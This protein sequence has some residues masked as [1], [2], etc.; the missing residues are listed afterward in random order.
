MKERID[1]LDLIR[2]KSLCAVK[3]TGKRIKICHSFSENIYK[4]ISDK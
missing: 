3:D 4:Y 1:K 2:I